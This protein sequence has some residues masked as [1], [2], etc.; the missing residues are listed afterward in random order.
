MALVKNMET[1]MENRPAWCDRVKRCPSPRTILYARC[2]GWYQFALSNAPRAVDRAFL[3]GRRRVAT[4]PRVN[5]EA[6]ALQSNG[7]T[8]VYKNRN[9]R[10]KVTFDQR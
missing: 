10:I 1:T 4:Y 7:G 2:L 6:V 8:S 5:F 9:L 3:L